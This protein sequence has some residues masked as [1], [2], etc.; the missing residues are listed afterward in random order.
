MKTFLTLALIAFSVTAF[1]QINRNDLAKS[2]LFYTG[3]YVDDVNTN[4]S[5]LIREFIKDTIID[6]KSFRKYKMIEFENY[7]EIKNQSFYYESFDQNSYIKL[8]EKLKPIHSVQTDKEEQQGIIFGNRKN[9]KLEYVDTRRSFPRDSLIPDEQTPKKFFEI[10]NPENHFIIRTDLQVKELEIQDNLYTK[11]LLGDVFLRI[12]ENIKNNLTVNNQYRNNVGDE[13]QLIYRRKWYN[14]E[15]GT[16]E[17]ENKQFKN[18]KIT[19]DKSIDNLRLITIEESGYSFLSGVEEQPKEWEVFVTDSSYVFQGFEIPIKDYKTDLKIEDN[20]IFLQSISEIK[21]GNKKFPLINQYY[22]EGYYQPT[23]LAF[24][25]MVYFDVGNVEGDI[26]YVKLSNIEYGKKLE[27]TYPKDK[28]GI[29]SLRQ[30]SENSIEV[31]FFVVEDSE[32]QIEFGQEENLHTLFEK[33]MK[34]GEYKEII[35]TNE[36]KS[37]E[38]YRIN[39]VYRSENSSGNQTNVLIAK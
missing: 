37:N 4:K 23:I 26:S 3:I 34:P 14:E 36:L 8:N 16:A 32:I 29:W 28:T 19:A 18:F 15:N 25:P 35:K 31:H 27:R 21:I 11:Q 6:S 33:K 9:L 13:I 22:S 5:I 20:M 12:S 2:N 10:E 17:Y 24:F 38:Y 39:F 1:G 7:S 30:V